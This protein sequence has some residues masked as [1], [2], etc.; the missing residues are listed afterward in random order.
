[1]KTYK[2]HKEV[3]QFC[4]DWF[5]KLDTHP[6]VKEMLSFLVD[7]KLVMKMQERKEPFRCHQGFEEWYQ[8]REKFVDQVHTIEGL[9]ITIA[10]AQDAATVNMVV[11][12]QAT[13][14]REDAEKRQK[15]HYTTQTWELEKSLQTQK[16]FIVKYN[17]DS[18][19]PALHTI[20]DEANKRTIYQ[21][22]CNS[23]RAIDDFRSK[24]LGFLPL[25]SGSGIF[26]LT[27]DLAKISLEKYSLPIGCFGLLITL[28]LFLYEV[29]GIRK[30]GALIDA[31]KRLEITMEIEYGQF[32]KRP[33]DVLC[34]INEPFA[35]GVIYPA[36]L[37]AW[38]YILTYTWPTY[39]KVCAPVIVFIIFFG[40]ALFYNFYLDGIDKTKECFKSLLSK[41]FS[42]L[43]D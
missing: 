40:L 23:Y 1:M 11:K 6:P 28:G 5:S 24:L 42:H 9:Q 19:V 35:S 39:C 12:W 16:L 8:G 38:T 10:P 34:F 31:G 41:R 15:C 33:H 37:A 30:C 3:E 27:T 25:A 18:C 29:Y 20:I 7:E 2:V 43:C 32:K 14:S 13:D 21:E 17:I 36:V 22:L 26:L 4:R